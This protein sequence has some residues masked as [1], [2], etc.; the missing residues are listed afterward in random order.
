VLFLLKQEYPKLKYSDLKITG[1]SI[2][3][4]KVLFKLV[5]TYLL[6]LLILPRG[7]MQ[8]SKISEEVLNFGLKTYLAYRKILVKSILS[9]SYWTLWKNSE[10]YPW[11][12]GIL[13]ICSKPM[14]SLC[15][16]IKTLTGSKEEKSNG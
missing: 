7:S 3:N 6:D 13:E 9:L 10:P 5:G 15:Y 11:L 12:N 14:S 2:V 8:N 1:Y 16:K 4:S